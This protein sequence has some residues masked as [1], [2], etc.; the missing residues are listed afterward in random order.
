M[1]TPLDDVL[2]PDDCRVVHMPSCNQWIYWIHKNGTSSLR[3]EHKSKNLRLYLN[4]EIAELPT[5]DIYIRDAKSR[6]VSGVS[7]FV[8]FSLRDHPEL[9]K[10]T[11]FWFA[12]NYK[13]LNRHYLPQFFWILNLSRYLH[14][15]CLLRLHDFENFSKVTDFSEI[16]TRW[17]IDDSLRTQLLENNHDMELWFFI[18]QILKDLAGQSLTWKQLIRHYQDYHDDAWNLMISKSSKLCSDVLSKT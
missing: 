8:E 12:K 11:V 4:E 3:K 18:D 17:T 15:D 7:T 16:P 5:V 13:F 6:Y 9:D 1:F 10:E 14:P 2:F